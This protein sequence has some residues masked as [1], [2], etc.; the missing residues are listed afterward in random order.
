M[1]VEFLY[2]LRGRGVKVGA[3]EA[4]SLSAALKLQLHKG[5]LDGFYQ[6]SRA[7]CVHR[8]QDVDALVNEFIA[9][10]P[11]TSASLSPMPEHAHTGLSGR[12][13]RV[14]AILALTAILVVGAPG[15]VMAPR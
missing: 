11:Q 15:L 13:G 4:M 3:Q 5:T 6:V 1:F 12:R 10:A 2:E 9:S 8:E 7:L 14:A